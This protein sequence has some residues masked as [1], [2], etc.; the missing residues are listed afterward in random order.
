MLIR[1]FQD[2]STTR[3]AALGQF[4]LGR[5][6]DTAAK[7]TVNTATFVGLARDMGIDITPERLQI[8]STQD[9]L[10]NIIANIEGDTVVFKGAEETVTPTMN[11]DQ[12]RA[13][14]DRMAKRAIDLK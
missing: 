1:E 6:K 10:R 3:L 4:L 11:V 2:P 14:V 12:A 7:K 13:T 5:A 8:L 9:P